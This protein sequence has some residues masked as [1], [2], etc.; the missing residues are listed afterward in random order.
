[1]DRP[2]KIWPGTK[3]GF[4]KAEK[5]A[6]AAQQ[7]QLASFSAR[8]IKCSLTVFAA[9]ALLHLTPPA[10]AAAQS[11]STQKQDSYEN[12]QQKAAAPK[13]RTKEL[14][15]VGYQLWD[16]YLIAPQIR[17]EGG[18]DS[19]FDEFFAGAEESGYGLVDGQVLLGY[20][21]EDQAITLTLKSGY[22]NLP[23]LD[24]EDR[25]FG[26]GTLSTYLRL[27]ENLE[28]SS[29]SFYIRDEEIFT[30][31]ETFSSASRLDFNSE[32]IFAYLASLSYKQRYIND[33]QDLSSLALADRPFYRNKAFN[34]ER[35]QLEA[36]GLYRRDLPVGVYGKVGAG[37]SEYTDQPDPTTI[38]RDADDIW[39]V[40]GLNFNLSPYLTAQLGWRF[41]RRDVEDNKFGVYNSDGFD[42]KITWAPNELL[43]ITYE[44]DSYIDEPAATFSYLADVRRHKITVSMRPSVRSTLDIFAS[45][46]LR[47]EVGSGLKYEEE[48]IGLEYA[49]YHTATRQFYVTAYYEEVI[50]G[51]NCT[52]YNRFKL[53][54]GYKINFVR[55]PGDLGEERLLIPEILP[56]VSLIET[57]IGYSRLHLPETEMVAIIDQAPP[58]QAIGR[59]EDHDGELD[60]AKIDFRIPGFAG[61]AIANEF[62]IPGVGGRNLSFNFAGFYG[63]YESKQNSNCDS[64]DVAGTGYCAYISIF[65][66]ETGVENSTAQD[67][68]LFTQADREVDHWGFALEA[69]LNR[70]GAPTTLED[71]LFRFG[72]AIKA[73]QQELDLY[74]ENLNNTDTVNY[75][76]D[77][78]TFYYGAY[79]AIDRKVDLGNRFSLLLN[80]EA[81]AYY[82]DTSYKGNY[83]G[84]YACTCGGRAFDSNVE[85]LSDQE[86]SFIGSL[87]VELNREMGWGK[88][89]IFAEG[90]Y[91]SYAPKVLYN[92]VDQGG[93]I[94][95]FQDGTTLTDDEAYSYTL[96]GRV[97]IPLN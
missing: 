70:Y 53:G 88:L 15:S 39:G 47:K 11:I 10:P 6:I 21:K 4:A 97:S 37:I 41:N 81:G 33:D 38:N 40:A 28:Y 32:T 26:S 74:S 96:G 8:H 2:L 22:T 42:A 3:F 52:D 25:W 84:D 19:N 5:S 24:P 64:D 13:I 44:A 35:Q 29:S 46:E 48:A 63:R 12:A 9:L 16:Y 83:F 1:M 36:G 77:L 90:E 60:G 65:D 57:R 80:A 66:S 75:R 18:Y 27:T 31:T 7:P 86:F 92:N 61:I 91:Y 62:P 51:C 58:G 23:S 56:M 20:I 89:G 34:V 72:V 67:G 79:I 93:G 45:H 85:K 94:T 82:G 95:G 78:D 71:S 50:E 43:S 87:R 76:E 49:Y 30:N 73:I 55:S 68:N 54:V 14:D 59:G 17:V 69:Q